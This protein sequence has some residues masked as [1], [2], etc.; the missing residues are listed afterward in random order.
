MAQVNARYLQQDCRPVVEVTVDRGTPF[1][2]VAVHTDGLIDLVR[3][4][5]PRGCEAC[6]SGRD[7][8]I[9]ERFEDVV[10]VRFG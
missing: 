3:E 7:I 9:R 1:K 5:A 2:D 4:L 10:D 8:L 6:L